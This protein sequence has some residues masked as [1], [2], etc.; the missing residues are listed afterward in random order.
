MVADWHWGMCSTANHRNGLV[1]IN[2]CRDDDAMLRTEITQAERFV[3]RFL[4]LRL[5]SVE[6]AGFRYILDGVQNREYICQG[7]ALSA[8]LRFTND[9]EGVVGNTVFW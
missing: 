2:T 8:P 3:P 4:Q 5:E 6:I 1:G 7:S 9:V